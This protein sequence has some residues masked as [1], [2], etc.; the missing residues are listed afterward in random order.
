MKGI[1]NREENILIALSD[2]FISIEQVYLNDRDRMLAIEY[3]QIEGIRDILI[4][5]R[6]TLSPYYLNMID[7][8]DA[9]LKDRVK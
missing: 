7:R 6:E 4:A 1:K 5:N 3:K 9:I 8:C 2:S